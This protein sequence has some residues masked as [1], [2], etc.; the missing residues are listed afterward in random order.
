MRSLHHPN[1]VD[2]KHIKETRDKIF[3]V[4]ELM[5]GGDLKTLIKKRELTDKEAATVMKGVF[6]AV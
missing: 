5:Y 2:F 4:M 6:R 3:I 1:I